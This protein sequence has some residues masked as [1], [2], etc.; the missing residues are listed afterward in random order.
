MNVSTPGTQAIT[1]L[2]R[3][4]DES[5]RIVKILKKYAVKDLQQLMGISPKL[6]EL[7][8]IRFADWDSPASETK[9]CPALFAFQGE[10]YAGLDATSL[11]TKGLAFAQSHLRILSGLYGLLRPLDLIHAYRLEMGSPLNIGKHKNLYSYWGT[12]ISDALLQDMKEQ[13]DDIL[14]NLASGEYFKSV[15]SKTL[16]A[17]VITPEFR[18]KK[19]D[20]YKM[21]SFFAKKARGL[22][23]RYICEFGLTE[24]EQLKSFSEE[25]YIYNPHLSAGNTLTFTRE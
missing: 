20:Q 8:V 25:G 6:A 10:V 24:I 15:N 1:T 11:S 9:V 21:I 12:K 5:E 4:A 13:G 22:M 14:I 3:F 2:P 7:N 16:K 18:D 23:T 19:G 17:R